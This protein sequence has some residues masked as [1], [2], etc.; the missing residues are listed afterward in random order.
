MAESFSPTDRLLVW[1]E[2]AQANA[3]NSEILQ[4]CNRLRE[5]STRLLARSQTLRSVS[6]VIHEKL[7]RHYGCIVA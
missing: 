5:R 3:Y 7:R 2:S 4:R 6:D 1:Y